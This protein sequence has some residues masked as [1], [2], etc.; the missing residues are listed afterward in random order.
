M[1]SLTEKKRKEK[2]RFKVVEK[3]KLVVIMLLS[4]PTK[5]YTTKDMQLFWQRTLVFID[6]IICLNQ[7]F[8][9]LNLGGICKG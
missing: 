5:S 7:I 9:N 4:G 2:K 8:L 6:N 1:L 3:V